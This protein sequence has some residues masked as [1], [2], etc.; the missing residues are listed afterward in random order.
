MSSLLYRSFCA[1][2]AMHVRCPHC[3]N[4][5]E[6]VDDAPLSDISCPSCGSNF[7]IVAPQGTTTIDD[8]G[9]TRIAQFELIDQLGVGAFGTVWRARDTQ[10]DR[11]VALKVPR[12]GHLDSAEAERFVREARAAAQ[13]RHPH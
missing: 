8:H 4:C 9:I 10:L 7:S 12:K 1:T 3:H 13:L 11:E 2:P 6:L 5:I